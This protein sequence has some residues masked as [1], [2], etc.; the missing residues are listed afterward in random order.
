MATISKAAISAKAR[1]IGFDAVRFARAETSADAQQQ[2][3]AYLADGRHG[4]M[5]WMS[6]TAARRADPKV[7]SSMWTEGQQTGKLVHI[8]PLTP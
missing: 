1:E 6:D 8:E 2:F 4:E 3:A 5:A 7:L